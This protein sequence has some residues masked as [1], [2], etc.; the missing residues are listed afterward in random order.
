MDAELLIPLSPFIMVT[1]IVGFQ[2]L[3]KIKAQKEM[4][5]TLRAAIEKVEAELEKA[6]AAGD[7]RKVAT[8]EEDLASRRA[9]LETAERA[10]AEYS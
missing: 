2:T 8:L 10:S 7:E 3:Q 4:Q 6:R 9:F 5:Q 1:A